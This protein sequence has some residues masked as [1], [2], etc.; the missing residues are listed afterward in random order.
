[1]PLI[2]W[3]LKHVGIVYFAKQ[4]ED[5]LKLPAEKEAKDLPEYKEY[6]IRKRADIDR[7]IK[8]RKKTALKKIVLVNPPM[9]IEK[10]YGSFSEWAGISPPTGLCYIAALI[11]KHGYDVSILDAE[12]LHLGLEATTEAVLQLKPDIVG[13]ACKTLWVVNAHRVA[14]ALKEKMPGLLIVAGGNHV[15]ALPERSLKEFPAFD[16]L[17]IG[18]GEITFLELL[19]KI[20]A[21]EDLYNVPGLAFRH[22]G[23]AHIAPARERIRNLDELPFPA[24]DLL[25]ELKTHYWPSLNNVKRFPA[26][27]LVTSRGCPGQCTFCDRKVF[28]NRVTGHS[29]E[30]I[31]SMIKELYHK[32]GMR[33][34][35][36]DDDNLL[37]NKKRLFR[38][39]EL[40]KKEGLDIP[41]SC[42][43]RVDT[44]DEE[45]LN[46]LKKSGCKQILYGI[47][48]GSQKI[49]DAMKKHITVDRV[50]EAVKLTKKAGIEA[51][52]FFIV[53]YPGETE[54]TLKDTVK[55]IKKCRFDDIA[56]FFFTPLPGSEIYQN[57][58][59]YGTYIEDWE[60]MN[61]MDEIIFVP[62]TITKDKLKEGSIRAYDS[63]YLNVHQILSVFKRIS[64]ITHF[65]AWVK[66]FFKELYKTV[67]K[68]RPKAG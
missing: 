36:F 66:Y 22:N 4:D 14:Q 25:P 62:A 52:G 56:T 33:Y 1:M 24:Y 54:E 35:L 27:S 59:K 29:P 57:V 28:G 46:F 32:Y 16:M 55:L 20:N 39:F 19:N 18:E 17:V 26:F 63:C 64:S 15:T 44:I 13:I 6:L 67:V 50:R 49:L 45:M 42:Q 48:S 8:G 65:E 47:E 9:Q 61:A 5:V 7:Q 40:L 43:S 31:V 10:V 68:P 12:A 34:L 51:Q 53:G 30:Y 2:N 11:R 21:G 58:D 23:E 41:F 37:L 38:T 60:K 3:I